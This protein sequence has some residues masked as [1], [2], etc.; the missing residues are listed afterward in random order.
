[1]VSYKLS[2]G[3]LSAN[4]PTYVMRK[5][6]AELYEKLQSG[7]YCYVFNARQMGKSSL[8]VKVMKKLR[9]QGCKCAAI[10]M[11]RLG[12]FSI[13]KQSWYDGFLEELFRG[14]GLA[15]SIDYQSWI[16]SYQSFT[17]IQRLARF[18]E[19]ILFVNFSTE[20]IYIFLDE[21]DLLVNLPFKNEFL[22]FIRS[23]YN[24]R[25]EDGNS[26]YHR[27]IF[28]FFGVATPE[29]LIRDG[30]HT[31][32]NIGHPIELTALNFQEGKNLTQ[33]LI[34]IVEEPEIVLRRVFDW[35]GGQ[36]FLTQKLCQIIVDHTD[37]TEPD[38]D[39]L[40]EE[41][42]LTYWQEKDYPTH[43]TYIRHHLL[44]QNQLTP[45]LLKL[46]RKI[47]LR[48]GIKTDESRIQMVLRLSGIVVKKQDR[49]VV[50]NKIYRTIFNLNWIEEQ[51]AILAKDRDKQ[52]PKKMWMRFVYPSLI[53]GG[54]ISLLALG[55]RQQK[56]E[57]HDSDRLM[58]SQIPLTDRKP[59]PPRFDERGGRKPPPPRFDQRGDRR[60]LPPR[61]D[62]RGDRRPSPRFDQR[63]DRRH[64]PHHKPD[65]ALSLLPLSQPDKQPPPPR[66]RRRGDRRRSSHHRFAEGKNLKKLA[67]F[68]SQEEYKDAEP[69]LHSALAI[70]EKAL[71]TDHPDI[72]DSLNNLAAL[73]YSQGKYT[74]AEPILQRVLTINEKALG[75]DH[76][77]I[78]HSLYNLAQIYSEQGRYA[79][80]E[81]LLE[82]ALTINEKTFGVKHRNVAHSLKNLA[83]LYYEQGNYREAELFQ[84]RAL[85]I[86][87]H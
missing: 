63:G 80:A 18:I 10:D 66:F 70:N 53:W 5:Q 84:Q 61:F 48:G 82:R 68:Y 75:T 12:D 47:L 4:D 1:M 58:Q 72:E 86:R 41:H 77:H 27:L 42:I 55:W 62:G 23:C 21:I 59:P 46:Y 87:E 38:I 16:E 83:D 81:L 29:D 14:F 60:P 20:K 36:P 28:C 32:F 37:S 30:R 51:L 17:N 65:D 73:Y 13:Q 44:S 22:A 45:E 78:V 40:V 8:R 15:Y 31:P 49:L 11:S 67:Q 43:L 50:F 9:S 2:G 64:P 39:K 69:L 74:K 85:D 52:T 24:R 57:L 19:E 6:D 71:G 7:E 33:G 79:E 25:A 34:G 54:V 76:P 3:G 26:D 35:T 56:L